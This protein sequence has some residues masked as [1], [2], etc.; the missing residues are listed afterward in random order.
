MFQSI[1]H[2]NVAS[3][4][5]GSELTGGFLE[6]VTT[7]GWF[8]PELCQTPVGAAKASRRDQRR[9]DERPDVGRIG[10]VTSDHECQG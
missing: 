1:F 5:P 3:F 2:N 7:A 4:V 10:D 9:E 8:G 6:T